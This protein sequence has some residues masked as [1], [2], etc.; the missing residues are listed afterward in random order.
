[1]MRRWFGIARLLD[2]RVGAQFLDHFANLFGLRLLL[3]ARFELFK[4]R[5][6]LRTAVFKLDDVVTEI[7]LDRRFRVFAFA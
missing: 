2:F 5:N 3:K 7:R 1:M 4:R 6:G